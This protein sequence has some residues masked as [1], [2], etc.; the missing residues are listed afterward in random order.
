MGKEGIY[1]KRFF[2]GLLALIMLLGCTACSSEETTPETNPTPTP[3]DTPVPTPTETQ[4]P[5]DTQNKTAYPLTLS[6]YF[7]GGT[8]VE[9]TY[10]AVPERVIA[11]GQDM[12]DMMVYFG[13][14]D[15]IV[16]VCTRGKDIVAESALSEEYHDTIAALPVISEEFWPSMEVLIAAE[17]D[18]IAT[19]VGGLFSSLSEVYPEP[20]NYNEQG[21]N[22]FEITNNAS[23]KSVVTMDDYLNSLLAFGQ[24]FDIQEAV[25]AYVDAQRTQIADYLAM[26][27]E[28]ESLRV[29]AIAYNSY[30]GSVGWVKFPTSAMVTSILEALG[31][32]SFAE[33][34]VYD[35]SA[36]ALLTL[37]PDVVLISIVQEADFGMTLEEVTASP[38][39]AALDAV[40]EGRVYLL[41]NDEIS[42]NELYN[43]H[44]NMSDMVKLLG[45]TLYSI[46]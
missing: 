40:A 7:Y 15:K 11:Y 30:G 8:L 37:D 3:T 34:G 28:N 39:I 4:S 29:L 24:L 20:S 26:N 2:A 38:E 18:L 45:D 35:I 31:A 36:E 1:M 13:L 16:G 21:I 46:S 14:E 41:G 25:N 22:I 9:Q 19:S 23:G 12:I 33:E 43:G 17:P 42:Y 10:D 27:T 32:E 44:F 5:E 6:V